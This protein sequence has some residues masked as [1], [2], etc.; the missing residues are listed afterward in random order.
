M[1]I[2]LIGEEN[3]MGNIVLPDNFKLL[4][5]SLIDLIKTE[6]TLTNDYNYIPCQSEINKILKNYSYSEKIILI[7]EQN[8]NV[9]IIDLCNKVIILF[10]NI[11]N[12][13]R[14]KVYA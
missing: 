4:L 10:E 14:H 2:T 9:L 5:N 7:D 6:E 8:K 13:G 3:K 1:Q 12:L 11:T